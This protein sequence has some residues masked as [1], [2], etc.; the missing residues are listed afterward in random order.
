[1]KLDRIADIVARA[2]EATGTP[3][4]ATDGADQRVKL[5][6]I[7]AEFESMLLGQMLKDMR[8]AGKWGNEDEEEGLG[9][10]S[11][12][13]AIDVELVSKLAS[14]GGLGLGQDLLKSLARQYDMTA[15]DELSGAL[16]SRGALTPDAAGVSL[17][18]LVPSTAVAGPPSGGAA[19]VGF[20][21]TAGI[22]GGAVPTVTSAFG[23]RRD[24][25][26][27]TGR[28]HAGVD[29][30]AAYGAEVRAA[31]GGRVAVA[32]VQ[33]GYG[34]T[35]VV[36]HPDGVTTR[37]A[38]L[39]GTDVQVGDAVAEGQILGRAGSSGRATGP[40]LHFEVAAGGRR[41]DPAAWIARLD[42]GFKPSPAS[43]DVTM[44]GTRMALSGGDHHED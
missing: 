5:E 17:S 35:V 41:I 30:R 42:A 25:L 39:S 32:G 9:A 24:P 6:R 11:L 38:H 36:E 18:G 16:G 8:Q 23:W 43:A 13:E 19:S 34:T 28:F 31:A 12:F 22:V 44:G 14:Q 7:A 2:Q 15:P 40:H 1:V 29:L 26:N 37:Y 27:G 21:D 4:G 33:S 3:E 20:P 10:S